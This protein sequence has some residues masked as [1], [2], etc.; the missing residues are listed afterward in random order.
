MNA[1]KFKL[2][3][4]SWQQAER[5]IRIV[6]NAVFVDGLGIRAELEWDGTDA[7]YIE[8]DI[9][10]RKRPRGSPYWYRPNH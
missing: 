8:N 3:T 6:R 5:D 1:N 4:V 9:C 10:H 7:D 2:E